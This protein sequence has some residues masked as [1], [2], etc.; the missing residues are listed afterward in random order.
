M[1]ISKEDIQKYGTED[2]KK[3]LTERRVE[4]KRRKSGRH[5]NQ[6]KFEEYKQWLK[7]DIENIETNFA[8]ESWDE[9]E[10]EL[11]GALQDVRKLMMYAP[12]ED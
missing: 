1:K 9:L 2:E 11:D 5:T 10:T 6:N 8:W 7:I 3:A 12:K 4:V